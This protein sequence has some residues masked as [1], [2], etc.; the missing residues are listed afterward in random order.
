MGTHESRHPGP[1]GRLGTKNDAQDQ[2]EL[3]QTASAEFR[4]LAQ[5]G[6]CWVLAENDYKMPQY[7]KWPGYAAGLPLLA[8]HCGF[9]GRGT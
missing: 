9:W 6:K 2:L 7:E 1:G 3:L 5:E 4:K 8:R